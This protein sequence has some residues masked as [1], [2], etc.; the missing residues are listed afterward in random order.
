VWLK[1]VT[2]AD[3]GALIRVLQ[4]VQPFRVLPRRVCMQQ[5]EL[6]AMEIEIE[7]TGLS[8]DEF[9]RLVADLDQARIVVGA[10]VCNV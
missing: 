10:V 3:M 5:R 4:Q 6:N 1:V 8:Y 2:D 7:L 9:Q